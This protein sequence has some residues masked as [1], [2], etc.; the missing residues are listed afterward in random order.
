MTK[1]PVDPASVEVCD[2]SVVFASVVMHVGDLKRS[3]AKLTRSFIRN[4]GVW[5]SLERRLPLKSSP[6]GV[7]RH[8]DD[9]LYYGGVA[10]MTPYYC[11][12]PL[13]EYYAYQDPDGQTHLMTFPRKAVP[14]PKPK[15]TVEGWDVQQ[16]QLRYSWLDAAV[17]CRCCCSSY[18]H[19]RLLK[20]KVFEEDEA[21]EVVACPECYMHGSCVL[22]YGVP[23]DWM[24][25]DCI[26]KE[27]SDGRSLCLR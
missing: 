1:I 26:Q 19:K 8:D 2:G 13:L 17:T 25:K 4:S 27:M 22:D 7:D 16:L 21:V 12:S 23:E 6:W 11:D 5:T 14:P 15:V 24:I 20:T 3:T 18:S 10:S 9:T